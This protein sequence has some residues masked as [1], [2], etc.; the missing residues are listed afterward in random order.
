MRLLGAHREHIRFDQ[1]TFCTIS[2]Y[3][4]CQI[5]AASL[6]GDVGCRFTGSKVDTKVLHSGRIE[7]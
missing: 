6:T 2:S 1:G 4:N 7:E 3:D 5:V